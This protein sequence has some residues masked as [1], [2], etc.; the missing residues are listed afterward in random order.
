MLNNIICLTTTQTSTCVVVGGWKSHVFTIQI[1]KP[2]QFLT[3]KSS[4]QLGVAIPCTP[5]EY[6]ESEYS[7]R[8]NALVN[9]IKVTPVSKY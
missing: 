9:N 1:R 6:T 2:Q 4:M 7:L 5:V 3:A 8:C